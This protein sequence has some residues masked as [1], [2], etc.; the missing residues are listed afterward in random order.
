MIMRE[1]NWQRLMTTTRHLLMTM[2]KVCS[3]K[4]SKC[5]DC[6][7]MHLTKQSQRVRWL[8][9]TLSCSLHIC[10]IKM[11]LSGIFMSGER[12]QQL[13]FIIP[14]SLSIGNPRFL[15]SLLVTH[16]GL[17]DLVSKM[18]PM[19]IQKIKIMERMG[20]IWLQNHV[21]PTKLDLLSCKTQVF[22]F[23]HNFC[24]MVQ[25]GRH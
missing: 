9:T 14:G 18:K 10:L 2:I 19:H 16:E 17:T 4:L 22:F 24:I 8:G 25:H 6:A 21:G 11:G 1:W 20:F 13:L 15:S 7:F 23:K 3:I 5:L 12:D